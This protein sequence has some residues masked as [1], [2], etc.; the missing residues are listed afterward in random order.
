[1]A[2]RGLGGAIEGI[3]EAHRVRMRASPGL[4]PPLDLDLGRG[5]A[6]RCQLHPSTEATHVAESQIAGLA[7]L[8]R[9]ILRQ[10]KDLVPGDEV[11]LI[12]GIAGAIEGGPL[13]EL[14]L[15]A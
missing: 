9:S 12:L 2:H 4:L 5:V 11:G 8:A 15:L 14:R 3:P 10:T 1:M 7:G 13:I 6:G